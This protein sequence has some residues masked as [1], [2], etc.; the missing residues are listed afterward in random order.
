LNDGGVFQEPLI[1]LVVWREIVQRQEIVLEAA[2]DHIEI[3]AGGRTG[4]QAT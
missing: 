2:R 4:A 3:K 1:T